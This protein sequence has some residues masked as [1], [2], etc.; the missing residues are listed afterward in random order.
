[1]CSLNASALHS[2]AK[3]GTFYYAIR[4]RILYNSTA[5]LRT[6]SYRNAYL[7]AVVS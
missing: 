6:C 5:A 3:A 7:T 1:M 2:P 4:F